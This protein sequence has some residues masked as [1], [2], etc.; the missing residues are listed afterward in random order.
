MERDIGRYV[1]IEAPDEN[2]Q[3]VELVKTEVIA[4][5]QHSIWDVTTDK[6][7]W[8]VIDNLTNLYSQEHFPS[9]DFTLSF[10][11]G[12]M[13]RLRSRPEGAKSDEPTPFDEVLRRQEQFKSAYD[14]A[15]EPED[16]Q[17][18]ALQ[19]RECLTM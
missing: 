19:L 14:R 4:G 10:H 16:Y 5:V 11:V 9:L 1:E 18:V 6:H 13:M 3:N 12:L 15:V 2:V 7:R 8:W 17:A